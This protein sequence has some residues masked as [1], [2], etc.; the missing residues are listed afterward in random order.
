MTGS[1]RL[2]LAAAGA[3]IVGACAIW[4][5]SA[6]GQGLQQKLNS[7]Q[8]KLSHARA[9]VG[10]LTTRISHESDQL[11]TL[12]TQV[13]ALRNREAA[14]AAQLRAKQAELDQAQARLD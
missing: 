13:A 2:M 1:K 12:T 5:G 9:H 8:N 6:S 10:V 11:Q 4:G 3:L 14:V 7:T